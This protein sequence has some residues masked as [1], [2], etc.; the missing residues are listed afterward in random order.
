MQRFSAVILL[1]TYGL[2]SVLGHG[3]LDVFGLHSHQEAHALD[4]AGSTAAEEQP[5]HGNHGHSHSCSH[6]HHGH[7][8]QG[9]KASDGHGSKHDHN[10]SHN[11]F[12][13]SDD[14]VVCQFLAKSQDYEIKLPQVTC[15]SLFQPSFT[16]EQ[17]QPFVV[18][19]LLP[20][21]RGPP[22]TLIE[23]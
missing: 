14:C 17:L 11:P 3:A 21:P 7:D 5:G 2:V 16:L 1:A 10:H 12:E 19:T 22:P 13:H 4:Y 18:E 9:A 8:N 20:T 6:H 15:Q 23:C